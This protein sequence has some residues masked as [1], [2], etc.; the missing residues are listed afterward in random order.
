MTRRLTDAW[1]WIRSIVGHKARERGLD[2]ELQFH[3][4]QQTEKYVRA[5]MDPADARRQALRRFG[6]V[7]RAQEET[8]DQIRPAALDDSIRDI[9]FG[10]RILWRA[11]GFTVAALA[12]LAIGIG[13]TA[14]IFSVIR[15][16]L[17]EPLPYRDPGR[18]VGIWE[19]TRDG[20][21]QNVIAPANFAEWRERS[22]TL[23]HLGMVGPAR[24]EERRVGKECHLTCRSRWSP[25]H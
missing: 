11:P 5:G 22:R 18:V 16:V 14:A 19:T 7:V 8:R 24:S 3:I 9:R 20:V 13:A 10:A 25:Y 4:D 23:E 17:L 2:E 1:R 21:T 15:T 6:G 12:T